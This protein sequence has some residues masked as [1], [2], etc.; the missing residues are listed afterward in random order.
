VH[1]E[2]APTTNISASVD[3]FPAARGAS[4]P[5]TPNNVA[6]AV[7]AIRPKAV[8]KPDISA[9]TI[10]NTHVNMTPMIC[11]LSA[12]RSDTPNPWASLRRRHRP[13]KLSQP[14]RQNHHPFIYPSNTFTHPPLK[15]KPSPS[16]VF[17]TITHP[18]G[19]GPTKPVIRVPA[20]IAMNIPVSL[21]PRKAIIRVPA[22]MATDTPANLALP[23]HHTIAKSAPPSLPL[24]STVAVQCQCG[25]LVRI[26][27]ALQIRNIPLHH[28]LRTFISNFISQFS[29]PSLFFSRFTFS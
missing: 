19:I 3:P 11:D 2:L 5:T 21:A 28:T 6:L 14:L 25:Q 13:R 26:S 12:L 7:P 4:S 29:F 20:R 15:P 22:R 10:A 16:C 24:H 9:G 8:T 1:C 17:E 18:L 27:D 23:M